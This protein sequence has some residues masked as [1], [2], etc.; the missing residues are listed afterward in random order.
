MR[1]CDESLKVYP[2][3]YSVI[4]TAKHE[5]REEGKQERDIEIAKEMKKAGQPAEKIA[6]FT[7][8]SKDQ[9]ENL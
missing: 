3:N 8:L 1:T 7:S 6:R 9:I 2:G 4:Q 5:E